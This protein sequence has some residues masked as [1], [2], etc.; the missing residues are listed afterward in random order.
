LVTEYESLKGQDTTEN[1]VRLA[2]VLEELEFHVHKFDTA[3]D[4]A[5]DGGFTKIV[6]PA[7]NSSHEDVRAAAAFLTGSALSSNPKVQIAALEAGLVES[8]LRVVK[9]DA[10]GLV[11]KRALYALSSLVRQFPLA[12]KRLLAAGGMDVFASIFKSD[13]E[14]DRQMQLK[15]ITLLQVST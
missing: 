6:Q 11:R 10:S 14:E 5:D 2:S 4:F 15:I 3:R 8:L 12:Q 9:L 1:A 13:G 7:L